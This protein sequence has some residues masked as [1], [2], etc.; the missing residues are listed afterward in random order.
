MEGSGIWASAVSA[1]LETSEALPPFACPRQKRH[2]LPPNPQSFAVSGSKTACQG[3]KKS[4]LLGGGD[5][6]GCGVEFR[7]LLWGVEY[8][9]FGGVV[10]G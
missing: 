5:E 2:P 1:R 3:T 9:F 10:Q 7:G 6:D 4:T 8:A